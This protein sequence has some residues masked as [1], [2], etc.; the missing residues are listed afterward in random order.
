MSTYDAYNLSLR[1]ST[2]F[3]VPT[4]GSGGD[5]QLDIVDVTITCVGDDTSVLSIF[6]SAPFYIENE[7]FE[8]MFNTNKVIL[9]EPIPMSNPMSNPINAH[10]VIPH[11]G[12]AI[13][14][15]NVNLLEHINVTV[16]GDITFQ[17]VNNKIPILLVRGSGTITLT[18]INGGGN[19]NPYPY[20][21]FS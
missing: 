9:K 4:G 17:N 1:D 21:S 16:T 11:N 13:I 18:P 10:V 2:E 19:N 7:A 14:G 3:T 15:L 6:E 20:I 8:E 5:T 12:V